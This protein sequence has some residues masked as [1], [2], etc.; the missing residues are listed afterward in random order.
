MQLDSVK[1]LDNPVVSTREAADWDTLAV[2]GAF[3]GV[4]CTPPPMTLEEQMGRMKTVCGE[5]S[6]VVRHC[7]APRLNVLALTVGSICF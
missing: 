2:A 5:D 4:K 1:K 3:P 7:S 6:K